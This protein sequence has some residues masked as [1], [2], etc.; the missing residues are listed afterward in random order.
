MLTSF[1]SVWRKGVH[2]I[3]GQL[4]FV[5]LLISFSLPIIL[6]YQMASRNTYFIVAPVLVI[7]I[8]P[9]LVYALSKYLK[10]SGT[11]PKFPIECP[12]CKTKITELDISNKKE[13]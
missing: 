7:I 8:F 4:A 13:N 12:N 2:I 5:T 1:L 6:L 9:L 11:A 3:F 10:I